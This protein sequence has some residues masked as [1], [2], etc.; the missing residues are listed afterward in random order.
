MESSEIPY[1]IGF[2]LKQERVAGGRFPLCGARQ[3]EI[4]KALFSGGF[5]QVFSFLLGKWE[6]SGIHSIFW[7]ISL[8]L[9][10]ASKELCNRLAAL[11]CTAFLYVENLLTFWHVALTLYTRIYGVHTSPS[12]S[13][14][15]EVWGER[16]TLIPAMCLQGGAVTKMFCLLWGLKLVLPKP[17]QYLDH[18]LS[19]QNLK[20][21]R[22]LPRQS[23]AERSVIPR[24]LS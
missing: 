6:V 23:E 17:L 3:Q 5:G 14:C 24:K 16:A 21:K 12:S 11:S 9:R 13:D 1:N 18:L 20:G 10:L 22:K 7:N 15:S 2:L 4:P 8:F 19:C